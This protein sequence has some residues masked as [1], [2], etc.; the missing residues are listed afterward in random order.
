M[1]E[2]SSCAKYLH[3]HINILLR[4][5]KECPQDNRLSP[6]DSLLLTPMLKYTL[7]D[8]S[9]RWYRKHWGRKS[10]R[11]CID[12]IVSG[13]GR[14][15]NSNNSS[16]CI[17]VLHLLSQY[18][19]LWSDIP[20]SGWTRLFLFVLTSTILMPPTNVGNITF[21]RLAASQKNV[22]KNEINVPSLVKAR[23]GSQFDLTAFPAKWI[24]CL[25][26]MRPFAKY[27]HWFF[28]SNYESIFQSFNL[29]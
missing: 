5:F 25:C 21:N 18:Q 20:L 8:V 12:K 28:S 9:S 13:L 4:W 29:T 1:I 15:R 27:C 16:K 22:K 10:E 17:K 26:K 6:Y 19:A 14:M 23:R 2:R 3:K 11:C 7:G 24:V